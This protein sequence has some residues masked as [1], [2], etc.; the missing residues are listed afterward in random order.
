MSPYIKS[1]LIC[2][3]PG[4]GKRTFA[5][6]V[7]TELHATMFDL[8]HTTIAGMLKKCIKLKLVYTIILFTQ[9]ANILERRE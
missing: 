8:T 1:I 2:G 5:Y 4:S 6:A 7:A 9:Q 3:P